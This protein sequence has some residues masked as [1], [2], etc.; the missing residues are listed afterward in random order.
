ME[1]Y[2]SYNMFDGSVG[3]LLGATTTAI[4][5]PIRYSYPI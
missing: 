2:L 4:T 3:P 5:P 1:K